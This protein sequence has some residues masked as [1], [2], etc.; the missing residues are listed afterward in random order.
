MKMEV[1]LDKRQLLEN[2]TSGVKRLFIKMNDITDDMLVYRPKIEDAWTI[3]EHIIHL[4]DSEINGFIRLKSIIAQPGSSCYVMDENSWT[5]KI[6]RKNEDINKYLSVF[7]LIREMVFDLLVDEDESNWDTD[8]FIR[9]YHG[10]TVNVTIEK[11]LEIYIN[12]LN[13]HLEYLDR[14][15]NES[16]KD[17]SI[18]R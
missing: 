17:K 5:K 6:R 16:K 3:K 11:C 1:P 2:Y 12:H 15:I 4:V 7:K 10:E 14:N 18:R 8:Y 13:F 9:R